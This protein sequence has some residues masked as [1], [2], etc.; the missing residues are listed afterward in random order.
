M[1]MEE[2]EDGGVAETARRGMRVVLVCVCST[3]RVF[4]WGEREA[5]VIGR[6]TQT[7]GRG[8]RRKRRG[9]GRVAKMEEEEDGGVAETTRRGMRVVLVCVCSAPHV[10]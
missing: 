2:E 10:A 3:L 8:W 4:G 6:G 9:G 5:R 1:K 7:W